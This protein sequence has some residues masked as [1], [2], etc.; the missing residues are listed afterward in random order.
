MAQR[1][2]EVIAFPERKS[3]V[4]GTPPGT[5]DKLGAA[6]KGCRRPFGDAEVVRRGGYIEPAFSTHRPRKGVRRRRARVRDIRERLQREKPEN[7]AP[8]NASGKNEAPLF[9]S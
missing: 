6:E 1:D 2:P 4:S 7:L 3:M 9:R 8:M 5:R